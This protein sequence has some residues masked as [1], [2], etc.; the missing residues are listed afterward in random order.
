MPTTGVFVT[1]PD[2][3]DAD[4]TAADSSGV[5][6]S[7]NSGVMNYLNKFGQITPGRYKTYDPVSELYYARCATSRTWAT[8]R[9]GRDMSAASAG[10]QDE[11][12]VDGF[13]VI[14]SWD[15][16]IQYSCQSNFILGIGDINT[17]ADKNCRATPHRSDE[18]AMPAEV[19]ADTT[20]N[21]VDRDQQG[22]R[23]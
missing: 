22:R 14:T 18:P 21:A 7:P 2:S 10:H 5:P 20:V 23:H 4:A 16:P 1:N 9:R 6:A 8:C 3:T 11:R 12:W 17:H 13:P 19:A 15:D